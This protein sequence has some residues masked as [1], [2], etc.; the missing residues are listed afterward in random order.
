M[1]EREKHAMSG[2]GS[3]QRQDDQTVDRGVAVTLKT[4]KWKSVSL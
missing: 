3:Q 1:Q 2:S 4:K